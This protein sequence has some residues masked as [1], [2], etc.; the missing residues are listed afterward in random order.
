VRN[1]EKEKRKSIARMHSD[2][3][4]MVAPAYPMTEGLEILLGPVAA[5]KKKYSQR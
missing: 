5:Q 3:N 1:T 2:T 4:L